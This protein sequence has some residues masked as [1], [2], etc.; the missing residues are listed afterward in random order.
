MIPRIVF[1]NVTIILEDN[2][3]SKYRICTNET[4]HYFFIYH[5]IEMKSYMI[6]QKNSLIDFKKLLRI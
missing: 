4:G 5:P 6:S 3:I 2:H 1:N